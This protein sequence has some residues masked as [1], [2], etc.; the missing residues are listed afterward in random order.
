MILPSSEVLWAP[1]SILH[2][3]AQISPTR[4]IRYASSCMLRPPPISKPLSV[5][6]AISKVFS[7][8]VLVYNLRLDPHPIYLPS[9]MPIGLLARMIAAPLQLTQFSLAPIF[10]LGAQRKKRLCPGLAPRPNIK[11]L[12]S[13]HLNSYGFPTCFAIW[14]FVSLSL[15]FYTVKMSV[16]PTWLWTRSSMPERKM[17][18]L[19]ITSFGRKL[20]VAILLAA[21]LRADRQSDGGCVHFFQNLSSS[22]F[23]QLRDKSWLLHHGDEQRGVVRAS[24]GQMLNESLGESLDPAHVYQC[25]IKTGPNTVIPRLV[26]TPRVF[27]AFISTIKHATVVNHLLK[28]QHRIIIRRPTSKLFM[29]FSENMKVSSHKPSIIRW[30]R[31][32]FSFIPQQ[33][34]IGDAAFGIDK[35]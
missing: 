19:I 31:Y 18:K 24:S 16:P 33:R 14:V 6:C 13:P 9:L 8:S 1:Y 20:L 15:H 21:P 35:G 22:R 30:D 4:W 26:I 25:S 32:S 11:L 7:T 2:S 10:S 34:A 3:L 12:P 5:S 29:S 23:L 27:A 28:F 17:S